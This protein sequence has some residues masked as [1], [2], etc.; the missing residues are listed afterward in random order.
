MFRAEVAWVPLVVAA[1][2]VALRLYLREGS[3]PG[4]PEIDPRIQ[5]V[6]DTIWRY[7]WEYLE[8]II[9]HDCALKAAAEAEVWLVGWEV[10]RFCFAVLMDDRGLLD[11]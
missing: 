10:P 4:N 6:R 5:V 11:A 7:R 8:S 9:L 1:A 3:M 2:T